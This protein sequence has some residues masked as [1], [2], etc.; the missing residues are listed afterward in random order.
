MFLLAISLTFLFPNKVH[1]SEDSE[2]TLRSLSQATTC[3]PVYQTWWRLH[4]SHCPFLF[5]NV[6]V[7]AGIVGAFQKKHQTS[8]FV[9]LRYKTLH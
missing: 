1:W 9:L 7:S 5:L 2:G 3:P 4:N 8:Q 6:M